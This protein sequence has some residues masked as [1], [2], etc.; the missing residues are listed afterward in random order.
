MPWLVLAFG[1]MIVP[2]GAVSILFIV[3]QP[4]VIGTWCTL[5]LIGAAAMLLQ[6]PY[7]F[8]ELLPTLQFI[9]QRVKNGC[10]LWYV[11]FHGDTI[12][13]GRNELESFERPA[14]TVLRDMV[15]GGITVP[16]NLVASIAIGMALMFSRILFD[17][18]GPAADND[19]LMGALVI[20]FTVMALAETARAIRNHY[21]AWDRWM[22]W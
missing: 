9:R 1:L 22:R 6:I 14:S 5:C 18:S 13:G 4:T 11:F 21:S 19:H 15:Q 20:T 16:W 7:S 10:S 17:A 2:L 3:I 12:E 8:D